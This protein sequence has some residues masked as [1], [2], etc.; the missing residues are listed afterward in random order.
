[1]VA[2][3]VRIFLSLVARR[4]W[5]EIGFFP[6]AFRQRRKPE[7]GIK[8]LGRLDYPLGS[9]ALEVLV[10]V[11]RFDQAGP[12][13]RPT[14]IDPVRRN[15]FRHG[16]V[17]FL[18]ELVF[19]PSMQLQIKWAQRRH[20]ILQ[21]FEHLVGGHSVRGDFEREIIR[22]LHLPGDAVAQVPQDDEIWFQRRPGLFGSFPDGF[23]LVEIGTF[24]EFI[25]NLVRGDFFAVEFELKAIENGRL[26]GFRFD[27]FV[28]EVG[29]RHRPFGC[30]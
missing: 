15:F 20:P 9:A 8:L 2:K 12:F 4:H 1:M 26:L 17:K 5:K 28:D 6:K 10:D 19:R 11:G 14:I 27:A 3:G 18:R 21:H 23:P 30:V 13:L 25:V 7:P 22:I 29:I 24:I 16:Q